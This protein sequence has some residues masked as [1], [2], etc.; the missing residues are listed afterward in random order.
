MAP[1]DFPVTEE[2]AEVAKDG[3]DAVA[4]VREHC[5]QHGRLLERF[6]EGPTVQAAMMG[7]WVDLSNKETRKSTVLQH[8]KKRAHENHYECW[9]KA[10]KQI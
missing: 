5:H 8:H 1:F 2:V 10:I 4:H 6:D 9:N 3:Q 7:V